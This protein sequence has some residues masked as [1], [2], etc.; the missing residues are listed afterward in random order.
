[1]RWPRPRT[2]AVGGGGAG[3]GGGP[4]GRLGGLGAL[5]CPLRSSLRGLARASASCRG[6]RPC[7]AAPVSSVT[8]P[9][10]PTPGAGGAVDRRARAAPG[11]CPPHSA[12]GVS[13]STRPALVTLAG[14]GA[15]LTVRDDRA[16]LGPPPRPR[17]RRR[18]RRPP[19]TR[20]ARVDCSAT[21]EGTVVID[22]L[23]D[24]M[25]GAIVAHEALERLEQALFDRDWAEARAR[26][27]DT[28]TTTDL[29]RTPQAT[30]D[31]PRCGSWPNARPPSRQ[32]PPR[33]GSCSR[34][35]SAT[36]RS[37]GS[38]RSPTAPSSPPARSSPSST[39]PT[40]SGSYST[41]RPRSSMSASANASSAAPP[42]PPSTPTTAAAPTPPA[43]SPFDRCQI[44]HIIP[45]S[46]GG[47]TTQANG[48]DHCRHH[49]HHK[50]DRPPPPAA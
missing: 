29:A 9:P 16:V 50:G 49:N 47:P 42:T 3:G 19:R 28:A 5:R 31:R 37:S 24:P 46:H 12:G 26:L 25:T 22:A 6:P 2:G 41:G 4:A 8:C 34:S 21:F 14:E 38:A 36:N 45:W 7:S 30:P 15:V 35:S 17:R 18:R 48:Q 27:G 11:P 43:T 10:P 1:M 23:L 13:R 44:D 39:E 33:P 32:R 20:S 40:W